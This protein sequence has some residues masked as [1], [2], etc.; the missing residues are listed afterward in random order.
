MQSLAN[1]FCSTV[2]HQNPEIMGDPGLFFPS[3]ACSEDTK[4]HLCEACGKTC[5]D[6]EPAASADRFALVASF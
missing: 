2:M 1:M 5:L 3:P 6:A 4:A